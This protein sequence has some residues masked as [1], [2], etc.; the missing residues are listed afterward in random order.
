MK[1]DPMDGKQYLRALL[2][3]LSA[4]PTDDEHKA[5]QHVTYYADR[6]VGSDGKRRHDG[7]LP[8]QFEEPVSVARLSVQEL[9]LALEYAHKVSKRKSVTFSVTHD[10]DEVR[11]DYGARQPLLHPLD[12]VD[13]EGHP[14]AI[15][16]WVPVGAP[17]NPAGLGH[18]NCDD[19]NAATDWRKSWDK[20][21]GSLEIR[22]GVDGGPVRIDV[23]ASGDRVATAFLLPMD[24]PP[25]ELS[26]QRDLFNRQ[27]RTYEG[28]SNMALDLTGDGAAPPERKVLKI[29]EVELDVT[30]LPEPH[31]DLLASGPCEHR[32]N[33]DAC[34]PCTE[35]EIA[36]CRV[37][38]REQAEL[39][40]AEAE[41]AVNHKKRKAKKK[42]EAQE[43]GGEAAE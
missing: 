41:G 27:G 38:V 18:L 33:T 13:T 2:Y 6:I 3:A 8:A 42:A 20:H 11:I 1:T 7:Y 25:A 24:H 9:V 12:V 10:G 32:D 16:E 26:A 28:R 19:V 4:V 30:G 29:G 21:Y 36:R 17:L 23:T 15:T 40:A 31:F 43:T 22:G 34:L 37:A 14:K 39:D 5:L 35:A